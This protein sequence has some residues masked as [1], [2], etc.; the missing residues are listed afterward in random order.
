MTA[1]AVSSKKPEEL[2]RYRL[3]F[4]YLRAQALDISASAA[5]IERAC[6]EL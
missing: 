3:A 1:A 6:E 2:E 4:E 5:T